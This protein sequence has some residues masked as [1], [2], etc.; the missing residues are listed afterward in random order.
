MNT[1]KCSKCDELIENVHYESHDPNSFSGFR[2]SSSFTAVAFPCGHAIAAVPVTWELRLDE[3]DKASR[4][5]N[6]KLD[7]LYKD[8]YHLGETIKDLKFRI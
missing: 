4:E 2:G 5:I 1:A 7:Q 3:L 8:I 6:K